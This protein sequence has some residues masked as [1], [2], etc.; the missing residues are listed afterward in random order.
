MSSEAL[1]KEE[2]LCERWGERGTKADVCKNYVA[3]IKTE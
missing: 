3:R 1:A 2:A